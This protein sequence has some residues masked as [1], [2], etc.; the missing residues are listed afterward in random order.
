[1]ANHTA[2]HN[3]VM[4]EVRNLETGKRQN[5]VVAGQHCQACWICFASAE[6]GLVKTPDGLIH[7]H[8]E[9][10]YR[11]Q[12]NGHEPQPVLVQPA[13]VPSFAAAL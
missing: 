9:R 1:M 6:R 12:H 8:C 4:V 3:G 2:T 5:M 11:H 13:E 10:K 7:G